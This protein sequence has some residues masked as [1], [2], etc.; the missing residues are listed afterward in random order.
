MK[1]FTIDEINQVL[2]GTVI[3]N[4]TVVIIGVEQISEAME[5]QLTF[6]GE[7]KYIKWSTFLNISPKTAKRD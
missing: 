4:L 5:N 1:Q 2:N 6:I 3:G 7:K